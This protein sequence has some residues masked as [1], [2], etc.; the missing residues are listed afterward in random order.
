MITIKAPDIKEA[1]ALLEKNAKQV[2]FA[3]AL[4]LTRMAQLV[5]KGELDVMQ[6]RFDRPTKTTLNSVFI[7]PATKAKLESRV[8]L[9]DTFSTGIPADK[10]LQPAV[11]GG[12]RSHKRF[13]KALIARGLMAPNQY[14]IPNK[15]FMDQ[16]GNIKGQL[17][18]K[19]LSGLGAAETFSGVQANATQSKRSRKKGNAERFFAGDVDGDAGV[20]ERKKIGREVGVRPVFIFTSTPYYKVRVPFF[21]IADNIIKANY[22]REFVK[23]IERALSTAR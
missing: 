15:A 16:Y 6:K 20:W 5:K 18:L 1:K 9:K 2:P 12:K 21:K 17:A 14:A 4:T 19:I 10:Y 23:A 13:E 11:Y 3:M 8:W 22:E 7:R